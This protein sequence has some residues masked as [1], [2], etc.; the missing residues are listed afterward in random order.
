MMPQM[1]NDMLWSPKS[2]I[3]HIVPDG[4]SESRFSGFFEGNFSIN[5]FATVFVILPIGLCGTFQ[6][7]TPLSLPAHSRLA[8][9]VGL[10]VLFNTLPA[11][12]SSLPLDA[13]PHHKLR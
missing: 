1:E 8:A 11:I 4:S 10:P 7:T 12:R 2:E 3:V 5:N 13:P 9:R 6:G